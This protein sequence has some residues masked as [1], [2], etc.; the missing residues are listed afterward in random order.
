MLISRKKPT[1]KKNAE[2]KK[3]EAPE[4]EKF[5]DSKD[6]SGAISLLEHKRKTTEIFSTEDSLWLGYCAY[7]A[8]DFKKSAA[9]YSF[10]LS[11]S[12]APSEAYVYLGCSFFFLAMYEDA[13][14]CAERAPKGPLQNR[15]LFH[16]AHKL[17]DEK[18]LMLHHSQLKSSTEDRICLAA[19]HYLREHYKEAIDEY[20]ALL[21]ED[22][23][24]MAL[25]VYLGLCY[26]KLDYYDV[27]IEVVD[28][29]L[30]VHP[31]S[32]IAVNLKACNHYR[33]Y[34]A[35]AADTELKKLKNITASELQF[36]K[37]VIVH[38]TVVF[39][40]GDGALQVLPALVDVVPEARLNLCIY[41]LKKN[42]IDAAFE[43]ME[44]KDT[45]GQNSLLR[46]ITYT[47]KG[48]EE[49]NK[50]M[51]ESAARLFKDFG[52]TESDCDTIAGRQSM[53]SAEFLWRQFDQALIYLRSIKNF[54]E[55]DELFH[56]NYG[57]ALAQS[58]EY[59]E[60]EQVLETLKDPEYIHDI[61]YLLCL[62][63]S[64]IKNG[65]SE[66]AWD[67]CKSGENTHDIVRLLHLVANDC[68]IAESYYYSLKA[69]D[70]LHGID[71]A[72]NDNKII[73]AKKGAFI[74]VVKMFSCGRVTLENLRESLRILEKSREIP[75]V[76][77]C[78]QTTKTWLNEVGVII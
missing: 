49:R 12:D 60:A 67:L 48:Y 75:S 32:P 6:Y 36:G 44:N 17:K 10:V 15:L 21:K 58:G 24:F 53:A 59:V 73:S 19:M 11:Q 37:D 54:F 76:V 51:L 26:Y 41:Y 71:I 43:M 4:L 29:Y 50:E 20:K 55:S 77:N 39:R 68:Y 46:A 64:Y 78:I 34:N 30:A 9:A 16:L 25:H 70:H 63:R 14:Q 40:N 33:L 3:I 7:H 45:F 5:L 27:S 65:K 74:G 23:T 35:R 62:A 52:D 31:D 1:F 57:Q 28:K 56:Y 38:N 69:F 61:C 8:G 47:M 18:K 13:R 72:V 66:K 22:L 2:K 42:N